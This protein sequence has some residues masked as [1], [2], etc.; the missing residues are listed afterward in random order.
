MQFLSNTIF[1]LLA[2]L[3]PISHTFALPQSTSTTPE[4]KEHLPLPVDILYEFPQGTWVENLAVRSNGQVLVTLL[5]TP[6]LY[7]IDPDSKT[8]PI[9]VHT[10]SDH[11]NLVGITETAEDIFYVAAGNYSIVAKENTPGAGDIYEVDIT[12]GPKKAKVTKISHLPNSILLNGLTTLDAQKGLI[13]IADSGAGA[14]YRLDVKTKEAKVVIQDPTMSPVAPSPI[15]V[16]G[17]K[18]RNGN[19]F[20]TSSSQKLFVKIPINPNG[21]PAGPAVKLSTDALA[22]DFTLD[23]KGDAFLA[24]NGAN[25]LAFLGPEGGNVTVLAGAPLQDKTVLAGPSS[26]QFGRRW[27]DRKVL[28]ITTT[29]GLASNA[30]APGLGGTLSKVD[31]QGSGYY[32]EGS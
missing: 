24:E 14:V 12:Q 28:Y 31:L 20:F 11:L 15:G 25:N 30:T 13:L 8:A 7:Q 1:L 6:D 9:L 32:D 5:S 4:A 2:F 19:L 23:A 21:T 27:S 17:L 26:C 10:F 16:N 18:I 3:S 22:D 29:G